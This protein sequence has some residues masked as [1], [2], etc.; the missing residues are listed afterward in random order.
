MHDTEAARKEMLPLST[1]CE[2]RSPEPQPS[3]SSAACSGK[4]IQIRKPAQ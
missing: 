2:K 3:K 4:A 1:T